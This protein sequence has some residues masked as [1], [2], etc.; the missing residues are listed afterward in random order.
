MFLDQLSP[1]AVAALIF[2]LR[3]CDVSIGTMRTIQVVRGHTIIAMGMGF[4]EVLIWVTAVTPVVM[5]VREEPFLAVA[6][7]GGFAT[8][9]AVG[10]MLERRLA[11]GSVVVRLISRRSADALTSV[12]DGTAT[13]LATFEGQGID[14]ARTLLYASCPRRKLPALL[15]SVQ[16]DEPDLF[17]VVE[18]FSQIGVGPLPH[19]TGW[20]AVFKKK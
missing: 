20:R 12:L 11:L 15:A 7:A 16:A 14:G 1:W 18:R 5:G 17:Y 8:G 2:T 10:I 9:N 6:F 4:V 19:P 13:G 3:I